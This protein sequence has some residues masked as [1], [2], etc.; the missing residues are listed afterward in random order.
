MAIGSL[1]G[2]M[3]TQHERAAEGRRS[4]SATPP[5][6]EPRTYWMALPTAERLWNCLVE[7]CPGRAT[8]RM[9][10]RIHF[11][12]QHVQDTVVVLKE[13]NLPHPQ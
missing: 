8:T 7:G 1:V 4:W 13:G 2:H 6:K 5:D 10:M 3:E 12:H 11:I 9:S